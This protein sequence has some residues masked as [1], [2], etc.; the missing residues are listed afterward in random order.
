MPTR[1]VRSVHCVI[2]PVA[3]YLYSGEICLFDMGAEYHCYASDITTSFPSS[4]TFNADQRMIY[5]AVLATQVCC[6]SI[7]RTLYLVCWCIFADRASAARGLCGNASWRLLR[8]RS[9]RVVRHAAG[10]AARR[11]ATQRGA[12]VHVGVGGRRES[13][14][15]EFPPTAMPRHAPFVLA[16]SQS[17]T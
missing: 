7:V 1:L 6:C 15:V 3:V 13:I 11:R 17:M 12:C 8:G 2:S 16:P 4:G 10:E 5:E 14:G 9:S